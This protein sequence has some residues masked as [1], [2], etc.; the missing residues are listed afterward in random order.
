[1]PPLLVHRNLTLIEVADPG[2]LDMLQADRQVGPLLDRRL[3]P[4][5]AIAAPERAPALLAHLRRLGHFPR[6]HGEPTP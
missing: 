6:L 2:L 1:M 4:T 3:S 5:V